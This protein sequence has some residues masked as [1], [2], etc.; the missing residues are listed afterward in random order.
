MGVSIPGYPNIDRTRKEN[1]CQSG[2]D[3]CRQLR[4]EPY[5]S[6]KELSDPDVEPIGVMATLLQFKYAKRIKPADEKAKIYLT[7]KEGVATVGRPVEFSIEYS[8]A[9]VRNI[10]TV[11]KGPKSAP[12]VGTQRMRSGFLK[13]HFV[14]GETGRHEV[15]LLVGIL[16]FFQCGL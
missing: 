3:A 15:I 4:I 13:C 2:L 10:K 11:V 16:N 12:S 5:V 14:P 6:A 1:N 9:E 7:D 8:D